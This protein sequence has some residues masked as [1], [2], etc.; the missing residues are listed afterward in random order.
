[1]GDTLERRQSSGILACSND[2]L[3][4]MARGLA[5]SSQVAIRRPFV[6]LSGPGAANLRSRPISSL[7]HSVVISTFSIVPIP[8]SG[9]LVGETVSHLVNT[10]EKYSLRASAFGVGSITSLS[11]IFKGPIESRL[12]QE[13][14][15]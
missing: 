11:L 14:F 8:V 15:M 6:T 4:S 12:R 7:M 5:I 1:M 9:S 3:N 13:L 10:D 2:L